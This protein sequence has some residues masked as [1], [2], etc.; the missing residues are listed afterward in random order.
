MGI[1]IKNTLSCLKVHVLHK[2]QVFMNCLSD[3]GVFQMPCDRVSKS[4]CHCRCAHC[5]KVF[6]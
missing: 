3:K 2:K 6:E 1:F 5:F 4:L